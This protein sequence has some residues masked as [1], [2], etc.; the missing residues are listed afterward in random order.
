MYL[1]WS[2]SHKEDSD[3]NGTNTLVLPDC[4]LL[5]SESVGY[6][7]ASKTSLGKIIN[8]AILTVRDTKRKPL[9]VGVD[10]RTG[11]T[12]SYSLMRTHIK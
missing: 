12:V 11:E 5:V 4:S 2:L 7:Y 10:T 9:Q 8:A 1:V 6:V 3:R